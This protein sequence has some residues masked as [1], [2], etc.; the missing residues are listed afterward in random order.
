MRLKA[1]GASLRFGPSWA[2]QILLHMPSVQ[3][4]S[5]LAA[6]SLSFG[7]LIALSVVMKEQDPV[8]WAE[9]FPQG[10]SEIL[11][12]H[13]KNATRKLAN[14]CILGLPADEAGSFLG[15]H[16]DVLIRL[17]CELMDHLEYG[18][19]KEVAEIFGSFLFDYGVAVLGS[20]EPSCHS[21]LERLN[22]AGVPLFGGKRLFTLI[23]KWKNVPDDVLAK[24]FTSIG[25]SASLHGDLLL[26]QL[27]AERVENIRRLM[28]L[29]DKNS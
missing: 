17:M 16:S 23:I 25:K 1:I 4:A 11:E 2:A 27:P 18:A 20:N 21:I 24:F 29:R 28:G 12:L 6:P 9:L 3:A 10:P 19:S 15:A 5:I 7:H 26:R 13:A 22:G 8:K 14:V